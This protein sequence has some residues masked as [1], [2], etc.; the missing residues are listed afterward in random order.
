MPLLQSWPVSN[1]LTS[2]SCSAAPRRRCSRSRL[3]VGAGVLAVGTHR[4]SRRRGLVLGS[5]VTELIHRAPCSV[6]VARPGRGDDPWRPRSIAVGVDGSACS[7]EAL[8]V[9]KELA[10]RLG[11]DLR[12]IGA[13][14]GKPV[15]VE[16]L[17]ALGCV[18]PDPRRPV[19]ALVEA[20]EEADMLVVG[21]RGL[22]GLASLG[23]VSERVAHRA[24]CSVL[25]VRSGA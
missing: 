23:S 3:R 1:P 15:E 16:A 2:R 6:F 11:V 12:V 20:G 14:G 13:T 25:V 18:G 10:E 4:S 19:D 17:T 22:H 5:L 8:S 24:R 9:A 7:L 21:S